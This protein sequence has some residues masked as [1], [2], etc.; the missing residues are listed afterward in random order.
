[1]NPHLELLLSPVF[2]GALA[3]AHRE[4]L[5]KSG[6]TEAS[7]LD[8]AI[9][10]VPPSEFNRLLDFRAPP[11]VTSLMLLPY[12]DPAGR[13]FDMFQVKCFPPLV[14]A[15]GHTT[16]YLQPRGTSPRVYFVRSVLPIVMDLTV[17]LYVVEGS[18]KAIAAAQLGFAAVGFAGIQGWHVRGSWRLLDDFYR[19]P[20]V[21]RRVELVPDGDIATNPAVEKGAA[22]F[23]EA[24]EAAGANVHVVQV[25]VL[26]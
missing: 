1:M 12:L 9:R 23:A 13:Y 26:A 21:G 20:L 10:S 3:P 19:V 16:K 8:Q 6:I 22:D 4:D 18:K 15:D 5:E 11:A 2:A 7:R 17:P 25:P 24:L 14:D